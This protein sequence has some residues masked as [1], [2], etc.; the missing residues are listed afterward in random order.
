MSCTLTNIGY[1]SCQANSDCRS[2]F[3][4]GSACVDG[5][6]SEPTECST[7]HDCRRA[8]GGG[9]CVDRHCV[10]TLPADS[11]GACTMFEPEA[12]SGVELA[13]TDAP[14]II[15]G[16][17]LFGVDFSPPI[18]DAARLAVR[19]INAIGGITG[20]QQLGMVICDNGGPDNALAGDERTA[21]IHAV[22]DYLAGTLGVP[23]IVGPLTSGD[24]LAALQYLM[25]KRYPTVLIS[26]SATSPALTCE[27]DS[28]APGEPGL[29]WRTAPSDELQG[30]VLA[31][32]V[33]GAFPTPGPVLKVAAPYRDDA[34]GL[35]LANTFLEEYTAGQTQLMK[36]AIDSDLGPVASQVAAYGPD[37]VLFVDVG[38]NRATAFMAAMASDPSL[39]DKP[40]YLTD[41]AKTDTL[42]DPTLPAAVQTVIFNNA[43][44]TVAAPPEGSVFDLFRANY[45]TEW[46]SDPANS[47]FTANGYDAVYVGSAAVVYAS[48]DGSNYDGRQ[49]A[50][51]LTRLVAGA[52]VDVGTLGW[53]NVKSG[54]TS[55]EMTIDIQGVSGPLDFNVATGQAPAPIEI[56]KPSTSPVAC[57]GAPPC[58]S[59]LG[60]VSPAAGAGQ[61]CSGG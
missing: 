2:A 19:E 57:T 7:G 48:R 38:G 46:G 11:A 47:A 32:D 16:M 36:F 59:R 26:P 50:A 53:S 52:P 49:V 56:W 3:G 41:G 9:A 43:V 58:F 23:Y 40:L 42:L 25:E 39:A 12:L 51:G 24:S 31:G 17:F 30:K 37:A 45:Q 33:A 6:C 61:A 10:P 8:L 60:V 5:F 44:G 54:L 35:G 27:P 20:G 34:Y 55:G 22:V 28:L 13:G 15:G 29:F 18:V 1:D 21:R 14:V 4:L